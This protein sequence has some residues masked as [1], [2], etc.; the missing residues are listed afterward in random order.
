MARHKQARAAALSAVLAL[1]IFGCARATRAPSVEPAIDETLLRASLQDAFMAQEIYYSHPDNK[2]MY[3]SHASRLDR[4]QPRPGITLTIFEG[5]EK[6]WS[7]MVQDE[8]GFA[9]VL[10]VGKVSK[11]PTTPRGTVATKPTSSRNE[12]IMCDATPAR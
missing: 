4:Y 9:C 12:E 7:G 5:T 1:N 3:A 11:P 8:T 10:Y 6:G 2:Y